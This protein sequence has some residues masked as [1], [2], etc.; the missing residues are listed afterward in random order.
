MKLPRLN[1]LEYFSPAI[2]GGWICVL[3]TLPALLAPSFPFYLL[4][5]PLFFLAICLGI[6][7]VALGDE[8]KGYVLVVVSALIPL[9]LVLRAAL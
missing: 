8:R 4:A 1:P 6:L 3:L 7:A 2:I 5:G 9:L